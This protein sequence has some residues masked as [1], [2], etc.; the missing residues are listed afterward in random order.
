MSIIPKC[1]YFLSR[2]NGDGLNDVFT[3][4]TICTVGEGDA[5][6]EVTIFNQWGDLVFHDK[7]YK[8]DW[9]GTYNTAELPAG[10]YYFV[11]RLN[12]TDKP[13]TGF[14]LIQR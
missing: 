1:Q 10:T 13:K 6:L 14:L 7:P 12:E 4:P 8:N 5:N 2:P 3:I 11:V 9:G